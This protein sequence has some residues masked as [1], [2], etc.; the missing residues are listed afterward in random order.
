MVVHGLRWRRPFDFSWM[1]SEID[2]ID[3][4]P[5]S[6]DDLAEIGLFGCV[7]VDVAPDYI[8]SSRVALYFSPPCL[9]GCPTVRHPPSPQL[10]KPSDTLR[11][12]PKIQAVA[13][14]AARNGLN[15]WWFPP[16]NA[17]TFARWLDDN[18]ENV[19]ADM[20]W[21][22]TVAEM[23]PF[24]TL[25]NL[26]NVPVF[27]RG[28][29]ISDLVS[30]VRDT[31]A[32]YIERAASFAGKGKL[33][34][35]MV[36][37]VRTIPIHYGH[38]PAFVPRCALNTSLWDCLIAQWEARVNMLQARV[39]VSATW[40]M[41]GLEVNAYFSPLSQGVYL[42]FGIA[43]RPF[44]DSGWPMWMKM[45]TLGAV[46][47]H[48]IGHALQPGWSFTTELDEDEWG[49]VTQFE[50]CLMHAF[51]ATGSKRN[52]LTLSENW[53]DAISVRTVAWYLRKVSVITTADGLLLWM[54]T[55]CT[56]GS[57]KFKPLSIDPHATPYMRVNGTM[58]TLPSFYTAYKCSQPAE[59]TCR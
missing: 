16:A 36:R 52:L 48:E 21:N 14:V 7:D 22:H 2:E 13:N 38:G 27:L 23:S 4:L 33:R 53:A 20:Q 11:L 34:Q 29:S 30:T 8:N 28:P 25:V 3:D 54:Q 24:N 26:Y 59:G 12:T 55:W 56:A 50:D 6:D 1:A 44:Y 19:T 9:S 37:R 43:Q 35:A 42:P 10:V 32:E 39:T 17:E 58:H 15:M 57:P 5:V 51:E 49:A 40:Q 46:I 41:S 47:A 45:S 18:C 31:M